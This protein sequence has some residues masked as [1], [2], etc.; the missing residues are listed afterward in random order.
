MYAALPSLYHATKDYKSFG[1]ETVSQFLE[2]LKHPD[3]QTF[4]KTFVDCAI[5]Q[6]DLQI[7]QRLTALED[8]QAAP[9]LNEQI[10]SGQIPIPT[11]RTEQRACKVAE[12]LKGKRFLSS[13]EIIGYLKSGIE[14]PLRIKEGQNYRQIKKEVIS[15]VVQMFPSLKMDK[16]KTGRREVRLISAIT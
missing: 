14:E 5:A 15:K 10:E 6:S 16:K 4:L 1:N 11:T 3:V 8:S 13:S 9:Q 12:R 2:L 7:L